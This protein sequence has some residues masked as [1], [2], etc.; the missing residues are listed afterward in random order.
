MKLPVPPVR[1]DPAMEAQRNTTI[2]MMDAL[3]HK[4]GVDIELVNERLILRSPNGTRYAVTVTD[5][6]ALEATAI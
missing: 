6:G 3:N 4:K 5:L 1:Y 2:E